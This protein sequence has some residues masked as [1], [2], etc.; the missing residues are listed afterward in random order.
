MQLMSAIVTLHPALH[1]FTND[2]NDLFASPGTMCAS[3]AFVAVVRV[4]GPLYGSIAL[5]YHWVGTPLV[6]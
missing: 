6:G 4:V 1:S 5:S 3:L 2:T